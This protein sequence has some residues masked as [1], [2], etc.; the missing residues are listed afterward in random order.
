MGRFIVPVLLF[1]GLVAVF[2]V[3]LQRDPSYIPSP[4][5][6]KPAPDFELPRLSVQGGT[7]GSADLRGSVSL[8]NVWA[9]WCGGCRQE[10][11]TLIRIAASSDVPIYGL[12]W[13]DDPDKARAW[14]EQLGNPYTAVAV[15][16]DGRV[17]IDW[18]VYGA[19][20]TFL[21]DAQGRILYK[22]I[23][24]MTMT[25]WREEFAPRI[26]AARAAAP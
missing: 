6:G 7:L 4:L 23:A 25:V 3:G 19:P 9:T 21:L 20:E 10:H 15:D 22:H 18:G 11:P 2:M 5:I 26:Q 16:L 8:L 17:A 12:D 13:K 14:L 1:A 24:P